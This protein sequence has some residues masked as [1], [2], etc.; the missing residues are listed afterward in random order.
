MLRFIIQVHDEDQKITL[1][2]DQIHFWKDNRINVDEGHAYWSNSSSIINLNCGF[3]DDCLWT[4]D[5]GFKNLNKISVTKPTSKSSNGSPFKMLL[6]KFGTIYME[7]RNLL[8][9]VPC[10]MDFSEYPFDQQVCSLLP[11]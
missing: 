6:N 9:T 8:I 7:S 10:N 5:L 2:L 3:V 11:C 1:N 4:P